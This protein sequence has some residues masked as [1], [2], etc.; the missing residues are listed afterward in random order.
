MISFRIDPQHPELEE[1]VRSLPHRFAVG[2]GTSIREARNSLRIFQTN[3]MEVVVKS[4]GIPN[5]LNRWIYGTFRASK[6]E[7]SFLYA[8]MLLKQGIDSP[9]PLAWISFRK[10][11]LFGQSYYVSLRSSCPYTFEDLMKGQLERENEVLEAIARTTARLHDAGMLH[12]DYS[13]GNILIG[14]RPDGEIQI[15]LVDLNRIR[16]RRIIPA[17]KG[18]QNMFERLPVGSLQHE[19][20]K[21]AY[22]EARRKTK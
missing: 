7:R 12:K 16:L 9:Q 3:G 21:N 6:A 4:F 17:E 8:S 1:F 19:I 11:L 10:G 2:E 18:L 15:E 5:V 22:L 13:R 14:F 20:M